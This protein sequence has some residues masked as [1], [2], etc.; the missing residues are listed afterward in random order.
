MASAA[1]ERNRGALR[2][3]VRR[4][5]LWVAAPLLGFAILA[6]TFSDLLPPAAK[7]WAD[8]AAAQLL[9]RGVALRAG[10]GWPGE[11][12]RPR[13]TVRV[14]MRDG[15]RLTTDLYLPGSKGPWPVILVRTP[16]SR[17]EG[18]IVSEFFCRYGYA[19]AVQD[20]RG[21]F[22]S[23]GEFYPFRAERQDGEDFARWARRQP[24]CDGK[25]GGF[26]QSYLGYTQ[27]AAASGHSMLDSIAPTFIA[28]DI[29]HGI[30][31]GGAFGLLTYLHWS[32]SSYG[33]TGDW[34]GA[35]HI[36]RGY[37]HF[38]MSESDD[39]SLRDIGFYNDWASHPRPDAYWRDMDATGGMENISTPAFLVA[40]WYD[41]MLDGQIRDFQLIRQHGSGAARKQSKILIGPWN[42]GFYNANQEN[43]GIRQRWL[44]EIPFDYLKDTK[45]WLD[46]MLKGVDSGWARRPAVKA[47][48]L[49]ENAW[50]YAEEWPPNGATNRPYYLHSGGRAQTRN[51]DGALRAEK[52]SGPQPE[53]TFLFDPRQ[54]VPTRGGSHGDTWSVGPADQREIEVRKDVLVYSSGILEDSILA[55]G[56][57][58][59]Q[60]HA[61][62]ST[63][64]TDFTAKLVDVFPDGRALIVSEGIVRARYRDGFDREAL[65][66]PGTVYSLSIDLG[67]VAV[68]FLA[69]HRIRLE[70]SSSNAPRYDVNPNTGREIAT[71]RNPVSATQR[72]LHDSDH[73][74]A[75]I[76]PVMNEA[77]RNRGRIGERE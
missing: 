5:L 53:D 8:E 77:P 51:G 3:W 2:H 70:I 60:L 48:V 58:R 7:R 22:D 69:G 32:L 41:F 68:R 28:S 25:L 30:Y 12:I 71:E 44:E 17:G 65:M 67:P 55:M 34:N 13:E 35:K 38:P 47:Y 14:A 23:E 74:S 39:V 59:V 46:F 11:G 52:P 49:G 61:A 72:I 43:Y 4:L 33:R 66:Q 18:K 16:Y 10:T 62:S 29:Y 75:L 15:V 73:P 31:K 63:P 50:R 45:D 42:H 40:G 64:D 37:S 20:T 21:R 57:V 1:S 36:R 9:I 27:W 26:G 6:I 76:L 56:Q 19:V 24:W 54:P